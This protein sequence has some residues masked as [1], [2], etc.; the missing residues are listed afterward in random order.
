MIPAVKFL[1]SSR[2]HSSVILS[3]CGLETT[4]LGNEAKLEQTSAADI[5]GRG[6][7]KFMASSRT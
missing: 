3:D 6:W 4:R 7:S 2:P 1:P 5:G